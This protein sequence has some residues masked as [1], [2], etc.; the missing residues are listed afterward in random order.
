MRTVEAA[1]KIVV[2]SDGKVAEEGS[3]AELLS[4]ENG[5]FRRMADLQTVSAGWSI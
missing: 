5:V 4:N 1:D 2:L 3:P